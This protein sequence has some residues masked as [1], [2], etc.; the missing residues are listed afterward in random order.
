MKTRRGLQPQQGLVFHR[1]YNRRCQLSAISSQPAKAFSSSPCGSGLQPRHCCVSCASGL[2]P[3][4]TWK[5]ASASAAGFTLLEVLVTLTVLAVGAAIALSLISGSLG[6]IR[7]VQVRTRT[8]EYAETVMETAL[9]D[10]KI[11]EPT[12]LAGDSE[13]G[14][15]WSVRVEDY[16]LPL[17]AQWQSRDLP[18]NMPVKLLHY[19]VDVYGLNSQTPDFSLQTL[20]LVPATTAGQAGS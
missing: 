7:K 20:K 5:A 6:N 14:T 8:I 16:D 1:A 13:D 18:Q 12:S 9:L 15:H 19:T 3:R 4:P 17:P 11:V 10:E 2:K